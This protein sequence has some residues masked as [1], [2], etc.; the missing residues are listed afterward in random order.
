MRGMNTKD[1]I[2]LLLLMSTLCF[3]KVLGQSDTLRLSKAPIIHP[4]LNAED[5][6]PEDDGTIETTVLWMRK[7]SIESKAESPV[8]FKS[9]VLVSNSS[10]CYDLFSGKPMNLESDSSRQ[11]F[12]GAF[13]QVPSKGLLTVYNQGKLIKTSRAVQPKI[14]AN[15]T[16]RG[17]G[18]GNY[19]VVCINSEGN[20][21]WSIDHPKRMASK[22]WLRDNFILALEPFSFPV[23]DNDIELIVLDYF[24]NVQTVIDELGETPSLV[25]EKTGMLYVGGSLEFFAVDILKKKIIWRIDRPIEQHISLYKDK[26]VSASLVLDPKTGTIL[27]N[28][29]MGVN[30]QWKLWNDHFVTR[31]FDGDEYNDFLCEESPRKYYYLSYVDLK[32][33]EPFKSIS[34]TGNY[35]EETPGDTTAAIF[36]GRDGFY[37]VGLKMIITK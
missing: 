20:E 7:L 32:N 33:Y 2:T 6:F 17:F 5:H 24:G 16:D 31:V 21:T 11:I 25:I 12:D 3:G 13:I 9:K 28:Y 8:I 35:P 34:L 15:S 36:K 37:L 27:E 29:S 18:F 26:L 22:V 14:E 30:K 19:K 23:K 10:K 1:L 4:N